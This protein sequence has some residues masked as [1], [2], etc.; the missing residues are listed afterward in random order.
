MGS[1]W[2][3][4]DGFEPETCVELHVPLRCLEVMSQDWELRK[5][6]AMPGASLS[7]RQSWRFDGGRQGLKYRW[8]RLSSA[9]MSHLA[10]VISQLSYSYCLSHCR[11][12]VDSEVVEKEHFRQASLSPRSGY[13]MEVTWQG[14]DGVGVPYVL[15]D[16]ADEL[17]KLEGGGPVA[18]VRLEK[19]T[20][21]GFRNTMRPTTRPWMYWNKRVI[22]AVEVSCTYHSAMRAIQKSWVACD[23]ENFHSQSQPNY[24]QLL[25]QDKSESDYNLRSLEL[26]TKTTTQSRFCGRDAQND[27]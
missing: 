24:E 8:S 22:L 21:N 3:T 11:I 14:S 13:R 9:A 6:D 7:V 4:S 27:S 17:G 12:T 10:S 16:V 19:L 1:F 15:S 25:F 18:V 2:V 20:G 23:H 5:G 26:S